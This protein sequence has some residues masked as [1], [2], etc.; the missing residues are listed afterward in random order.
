[1]KNRIKRFIKDQNGSEFIDVA[2]II[3]GSILILYAIYE[4]IKAV[5]V[6]PENSQMG[7]IKKQ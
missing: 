5:N 6:L 1:M 7:I 3:A 4:I 2:V